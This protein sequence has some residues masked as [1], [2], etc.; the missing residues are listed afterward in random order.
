MRLPNPYALI[1][2]LILL[3]ALLFAGELRSEPDVRAAQRATVIVEVY[4][5]ERL[6]GHGSGV[7]TRYGIVTAGHVLPDRA[8]RIVV[9]Y[10]GGEEREA[11]ILA[12]DY[13]QV[14]ETNWRGQR[15]R[16]TV[17]DIAVLEAVPVP[18][19]RP[20]G[21][22]CTSPAP[23]KPVYQVGH[24]LNLTW[25]VTQGA[26]TATHTQRRLPGA[27]LL[28]DAVAAQGNSGGGVFDRRGRL[29]GI[30]VQQ[31]IAG[32]VQ[33]P[34]STVVVPTGNT[35]AVPAETVCAFLGVRPSHPRHAL[36]TRGHHPAPGGA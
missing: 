16:R 24:P 15:V 26:V 20:V 34:M 10:W 25:I 29:I 35:V 30:T 6:L 22:R 11:R 36:Y 31:Q 33:T 14:H 1:A 17:S 8:D 5:G 23:G 13:E 28:H 4:D 19:Y 9:R 7:L 27:W 32:A 18:G 21:V 2:A 12:R 3:F